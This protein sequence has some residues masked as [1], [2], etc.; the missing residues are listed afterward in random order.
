MCL[1]PRLW[2]RVFAYAILLIL[3]SHL[4]SSAMFR[5]MAQRDMHARFLAELATNAASAIE[6]REK[7]SLGALIK[8]WLL[9]S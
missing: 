7:D 9:T 8:F 2:Q 3:V 4:V 5:L 1:L 6:G